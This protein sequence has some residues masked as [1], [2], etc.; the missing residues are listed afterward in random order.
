MIPSMSSAHQTSRS[1]RFRQVSGAISAL[2]VAALLAACAADPQYRAPE[3]D[4][5]RGWIQPADTSATEAQL[6]AWWRSLGDPVLERLVEAALAQNLDV[7]QARSRIAEARA[8][9]DAAAG[10][11]EP[12]LNVGASVTRR[13]Q[14]RNGPLPIGSLPGVSRDQTIHEGGFDA[15]WEIDLFGRVRHS[16]ESADARV[17]AAQEEANAAHVSVA[18]EV[19]RT[20]LSL[21]GAQRELKAG[22]A[23]VGTLRRVAETVRR[24]AAAGDLAMGEVERSQAKFQAGAAVLPGIR[25][26]VRATALGLGVLLG[27]L[28][29]IELSLADS[30]RD[31]IVLKAIP[32]GERADVLRR[33]PDV[34]AAERHLAAATADIGVATA[35]WFPRLAIS[36]AGGFQAL[37][38]GDLLKSSSQVL[39]LTPLI[40]WRILDGGRVNAYIRAAQ[41]RQQTAARAY[42]KAVLSALADAER[43]LSNYR[44][45]LASVSGQ[46]AALVSARR[47]YDYAKRRFEAG[48]V[49]R[50][51]LL[52]AERSMREGEGACARART[53]AAIDLI[54][55]YK[56]LGG[57]W[58]EGSS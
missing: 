20:Y 9:R 48:D 17:Q 1:R 11:R 58:S 5:G 7:L 54:A 24:R 36:T 29:E 16:V 35:R 13:R 30:D 40:S 33:R 37:D 38:L 55:L 41:A 6:A 25:A 31:E 51:D 50:L 21:R 10:A 52:D 44:F 28:P 3:P 8:L 27:R 26:R 19:A 56:A 32:V 15:A 53:I 42:E 23:W 34:R 43:A 4:A 45:S 18:A 49:A 12:S 47:D 57:G 2:A 14:S 46:C 39:S 22:E